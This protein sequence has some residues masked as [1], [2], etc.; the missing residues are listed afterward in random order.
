MPSQ[1]E[2][3]FA[4]QAFARQNILQAL[5]T[6]GHSNAKY[7]SPKL[8]ADVKI[9]QLVTALRIEMEARN[10]TPQA[11]YEDFE[12]KA[13]PDEGGER[14]KFICEWSHSAL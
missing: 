13:W 5:I 4:A 6:H 9:W 12:W 2:A 3:S 1:H 14:H 8:R 7:L 11:E 10:D